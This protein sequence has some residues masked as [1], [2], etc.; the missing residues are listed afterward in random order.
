MDLKYAALGLLAQRPPCSVPLRIVAEIFDADADADSTD[1]AELARASKGGKDAE[2][3]ITKVS[4]NIAK[5]Q[6]DE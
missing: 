3:R 5:R 4:N 1:T 2:M 6:E